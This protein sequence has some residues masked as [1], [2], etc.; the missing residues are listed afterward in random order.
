MAYKTAKKRTVKNLETKTTRLKR[1]GPSERQQFATD[2]RNA[3]L[4]GLWR[5]HIDVRSGVYELIFT[6]S[7][8]CHVILSSYKL[9]IEVIFKQPQSVSPPVYNPLCPINIEFCEFL[10]PSSS[11][12]LVPFCLDVSVQSCFLS[13]Y[14]LIWCQASW[15]H[16]SL[17][18]QWEGR[19]HRAKEQPWQ[20][21]SH[22]LVWKYPLSLELFLTV[23]EY[24]TCPI[25]W[26]VL[27]EVSLSV[28]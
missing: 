22:L 16:R 7:I 20:S 3:L 17:V 27:R 13:N 23:S 21:R 26:D 12:P 6:K 25:L 15:F 18:R 2:P 10:P 14:S 8:S 24:Q 4:W 9:L 28:F 11:G 19:K 5:C 1:S